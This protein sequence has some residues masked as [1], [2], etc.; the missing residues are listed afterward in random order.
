MPTISC[1]SR[2][3]AS[4]LTIIKKCRD[5]FIREQTNKQFNLRKAS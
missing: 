1:K 2:Q 5:F 4:N 3:L